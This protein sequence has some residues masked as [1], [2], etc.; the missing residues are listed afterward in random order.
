MLILQRRAGQTIKIGDD[1]TVTINRTRSGSVTLGIEAPQGVAIT[2]TGSPALSHGHSPRV[3]AR[4]PIST[5]VL[6]SAS[7][8]IST[9][10]RI[11][12]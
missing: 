2:E 11:E 4:F 1:I 10:G 3:A 8:P 5:P 12:S 6:T 7:T 9:P